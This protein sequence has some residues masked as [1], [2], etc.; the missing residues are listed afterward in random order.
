MQIKDGKSDMPKKEKKRFDDYIKTLPNGEYSLIVKKIGKIRSL[1][2]NRYYWGV[3][4][5]TIRSHFGYTPMEM[6]DALKWQF[7][8]EEKKPIPTIKSTAE[9]TN[10]EFL[11]YIQNIS[12]WASTEYSITIPTPEE[13]DY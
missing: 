12:I 1:N 9:L 7:L 3:V 6:H 2:L 11:E 10:S 5:E 4:I 8:R 13:V